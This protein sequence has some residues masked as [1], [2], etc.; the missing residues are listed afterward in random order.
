[1]HRP[2]RWL[3]AILGGLA[4]GAVA[5]PAIAGATTDHHGPSTAQI[6]AALDTRFQAAVKNND[7]RTIDRIL[8]DDYVLV[9]GN[10]STQ[11]KAQQVDPAREKTCTYEHQEEIDNSQRVHVFGDSTATVTAKLWIQG[12]CQG[13]AKPSDIKLWFSDTYVRRDG[14][15][16]YA[17]GQASLS[18]P[19][20]APAK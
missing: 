8:S 20:P 17:F 6:I 13:D 1:M 9:L 12:I 5:V 7:A 18:L 11:N 3:V 19:P 15:W 16:Q 2:S 4:A 10:G 14:R